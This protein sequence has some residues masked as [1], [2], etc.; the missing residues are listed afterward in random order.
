MNK[1]ISKLP[2]CYWTFEIFPRYEIEQLPS[3]A[4]VLLYWKES[5]KQFRGGKL[6][7]F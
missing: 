3:A 4:R 2:V 7:F 1:Q 5:K 6:T